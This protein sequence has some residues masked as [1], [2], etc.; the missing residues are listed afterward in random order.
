MA[1]ASR[2]RVVARKFGDKKHEMALKTR[3]RDNNF[4]Q[5]KDIRED[6]GRRQTKFAARKS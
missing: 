5:S 4:K 2:R 1:K 3:K 6:R